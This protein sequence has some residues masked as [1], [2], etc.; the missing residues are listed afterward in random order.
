MKLQNI[1][2][3]EDAKNATEFRIVDNSRFAH[4]FRSE[5]GDYESG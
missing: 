5:M 2:R 3:I 1:E 4:R